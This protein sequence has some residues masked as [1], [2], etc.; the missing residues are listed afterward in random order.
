MGSRVEAYFPVQRIAQA[1]QQ[2]RYASC[3]SSLAVDVHDTD[4]RQGGKNA[5]VAATGLSVHS[6]KGSTLVSDVGQARYLVV[7]S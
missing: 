1:C 5:V 4:P 2:C 3:L 6:V 7:M